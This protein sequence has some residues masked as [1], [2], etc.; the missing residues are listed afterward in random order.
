MRN[1][2]K[3][4]RLGALASGL[5]VSLFVLTT[6][7]NVQ[8]RARQ[9]GSRSPVLI[10]LFTSEGCS[11]CPPADAFLTTLDQSQPI[12]YAQLIVLSEHV[13]YWDSDGWRDPY[14]SHDL[15]VRQRDYAY[16]FQLPSS[17]T[18]QM[19][20]DGTAQFAGNDQKTGF[21]DIEKAAGAHLVPVR[22]SGI[23][24]APDKHLRLHIDIGAEQRLSGDV[25]V[26]LADDSDASSVK[27]GENAGRVLN[28]VAVVRGL[29]RVG[30]I[31]QGV[32]SADPAISIGN[33]NPHNLRIIAFAQQGVGGKIVALG[34]A[35]R[36]N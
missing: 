10:E 16:R 2:A 25:W 30:S 11:D 24:L 34:T 27:A 6:R 35:R 33:A 23:S 32:F 18:P 28:H 20:V 15:T 17:Y 8:A 29:S 14:S 13:D 31:R 36:P 7:V 22:L 3:S 21:A 9:A 4:L 12:P 19:V 1:R 26:A 5:L